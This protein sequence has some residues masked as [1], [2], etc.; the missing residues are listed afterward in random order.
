MSD[1]V[2]TL[3]PLAALPDKHFYPWKKGKIS[4][5]CVK[6][7]D[8]THDVKTFTFIA[9]DPTQLFFYKPGQ[10]INLYLEID[11]TPIVRSYTLAS[12]PSRPYNI[13]I[14]VKRIP[15]GIV[16][17][18]LHDN[19]NVGNTIIADAPNGSFN[20]FDLP[21]PKLLFISGG[22][23][24]TPVMSMLRWL[25]DSSA[26][27]DIIFI[28]HAHTPKDVI[29][30]Q[31]LALLATQNAHLK[32]VISVSKADDS[33]HGMT[34]R[35]SATQL[36]SIAP[37]LLERNVYACGPT[38][39]MNTIQDILI[40]LNFPLQHYHFESFT[41]YR[42]ST[43]DKS[44]KD[45]KIIFQQSQKEIICSSNQAILDSAEDE[46]INMPS[47]CRSGLC[48][49]CKVLKI[50]GEVIMDDDVDGL[51]EEER[52]EGYILTCCALPQGSVTIDA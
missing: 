37:D 25:T 50:A 33:W 16:S 34:E 10:F 17:N 26:E 44:V 7:I 30:A 8:E 29:F 24:I 4:L 48:G 2:T 27:A 19:C 31:E 38:S 11:N 15:N 3:W 1:L 18:W 51:S 42:S 35:V 47:G 23:G 39:Y 36:L 28:H 21:A 14:T 9:T 49:T 40:S 6:I 22:S 41:S 13:A 12:S 32:V 5:R 20:C 52:D 43:T 45:A 46:N